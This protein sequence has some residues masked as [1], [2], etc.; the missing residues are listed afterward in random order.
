MLNIQR[1]RKFLTESSGELSI[2]AVCIH[3]HET[4]GKYV[5]G[6]KMITASYSGILYGSDPSWAVTVAQKKDWQT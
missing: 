1:D 4:V 6:P 5:G 2:T 3:S